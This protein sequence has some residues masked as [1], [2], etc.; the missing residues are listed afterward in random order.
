MIKVNNR[1][2]GTTTSGKKV[3][4]Y[5]NNRICDGYTMQDHVE[6]AKIAN[7]HNETA[8]ADY[9]ADRVRFHSTKAAITAQQVASAE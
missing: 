4:L 9:D 5:P 6:A 1:V 8:G 7:E 3:W 2:I